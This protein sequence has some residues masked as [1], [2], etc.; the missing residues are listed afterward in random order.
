MI[1]GAEP[2]GIVAQYGA[3]LQNGKQNNRITRSSRG[4]VMG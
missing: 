4:D 2:F 1:D 3:S